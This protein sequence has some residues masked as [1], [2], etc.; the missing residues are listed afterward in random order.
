MA[1]V[2]PIFPNFTAGEL[3]PLLYGRVDFEKYANGAK[4]I[5]N[6]FARPHGPV[7]RRAGTHFVAEVKDSTKKTA[8]I[9]FEFNI[10]QA[11][12]IE[13]GNLYMRFY[14]DGGRIESPPGTAV[15]ISTPYTEAQLFEV[16]YIQSADTMYCFQKDTS[17]RKLVRL[18]HTSW[19]LKEV[20]FLPPAT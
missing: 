11:Y 1:R 10:E 16:K 5:V 3:S 13:F 18:S 2:H 15:E 7:E 4:Q 14:K 17:V 9:R 8:L 19:Q 6:M 20:N 12:I